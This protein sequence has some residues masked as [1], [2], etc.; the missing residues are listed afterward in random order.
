MFE[1]E[2]TFMYVYTRS[3]LINHA[4]NVNFFLNT[5]E[6]NFDVRRLI[7]NILLHQVVEY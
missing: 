3:V 7:F 2:R 1:C 5:I 4:M 6:M